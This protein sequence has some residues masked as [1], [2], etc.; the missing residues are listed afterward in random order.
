[1]K[2]K[3]LDLNS[4]NMS[5]NDLRR[6]A[7]V[8]ENIFNNTTDESLLD[9]AIYELRY[10]RA[11]HGHLIA[12]ARQEAVLDASNRKTAVESNHDKEADVLA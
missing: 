1:M 6:R 11:Y 5:I 10:L 12:L 2:R 8:A 3:K 9:A 7:E 4:L